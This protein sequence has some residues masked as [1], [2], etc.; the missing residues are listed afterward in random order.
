[1]RKEMSNSARL[2]MFAP[3]DQLGR[4]EA[5]AARLLDAITLGLLDDAE[6][7]PSEVELAAQ[8]RV[9]TVTVREAL[10]VLR[11]Q[12]L[13]ETRRGRGGGSFVRTPAWPAPSSWAQRLRLVS[14]AD[15]R[16]FGDHYLAVAGSAAKL[17]SERSSQEDLERLRLTSEDLLGTTG[18]E[19][20]RAERHFHLEI[21]AAAQSPR[22]TNQEVQ[23]QG[24]HG[25]LL[26]VP[27]DGEDT[28]RQSY[29]EHHA[30]VTAIAAADGDL[31]RKLTEEHILSALDR[32]VDLHLSLETP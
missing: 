22:L 15:L 17:A 12:G 1:M 21:A 3:L 9:S 18:P 6:Q 25:G 27:L 10:A 24:E 5:V 32:L 29:A 2:A 16:D 14:L 23:L 28:C 13:V 4:A 19:A 11:Q 31:A 20:T 30:I 8:F 26:W 7:L